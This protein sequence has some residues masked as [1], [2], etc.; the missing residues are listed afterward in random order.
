LNYPYKKLRLGTTPPE[1]SSTSPSWLITDK[2]EETTEQ[3]KAGKKLVI[4][5]I[6]NTSA[7]NG[8]L[9]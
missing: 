3:N 5:L 6:Q 1:H 7:I 2:T 9:S 8:V 4:Q